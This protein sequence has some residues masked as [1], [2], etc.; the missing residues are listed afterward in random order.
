MATYSMGGPVKSKEDQQAEQA[1]YNQWLKNGQA[2]PNPLYGAAAQQGATTNGSGNDANRPSNTRTNIQNFYRPPTASPSSLVRNISNTQLP[3]SYS[4]YGPAV[5]RSQDSAVAIDNGGI[6]INATPGL[7]PTKNDPTVAGTSVD[8][9]NPAEASRLWTGPAPGSRRPQDSTYG[10]QID[11]DPKRYTDGNGNYFGTTGSVP[12]GMTEISSNTSTT[13][14]QSLWN[15]RQNSRRPRTLS[16]NLSDDT[17]RSYGPVDP[18]TSAIAR[19]KMSGRS[20]VSSSSNTAPGSASAVQQARWQGVSV[21]GWNPSPNASPR[22]H[23]R[24]NRQAL[25]T[26]TPQ[27]IDRTTT[28]DNGG[29][30]VN[31]GPGLRPAENNP[32]VAGTSTVSDTQRTVNDLYSARP[33]DARRRPKEGRGGTRIDGETKYYTD[34]DGNYIGTTGSI[35]T[36]ATETSAPTPRTPSTKT[37]TQRP[38]RPLRRGFDTGNTPSRVG[39]DVDPRPDVSRVYESNGSYRETTRLPDGTTCLLYTSPSPRD[40]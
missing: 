4:P 16:G 34:G 37:A 20:P 40:S 10:T 12:G 23:V 15:Q 29:V 8:R 36:G 35:P 38:E 5:S 28:I 21:G 11:G 13:P 19:D 1:A 39:V 3:N 6:Q 14:G 25:R 18:V 2:G 9:S 22:A 24:S 31:V 7:Q 17:R 30:Q 27:A 33:T 26:P 32:Q